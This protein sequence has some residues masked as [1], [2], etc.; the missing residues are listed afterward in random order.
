M[1]A[2]ARVRGI[3]CCIPRVLFAEHTE[4]VPGTK[5]T[6]RLQ[7]RCAGDVTGNLKSRMPEKQRTLS[8]VGNSP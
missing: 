6:C 3:T 1:C 8:R 2:R 4:R 7:A 5:R